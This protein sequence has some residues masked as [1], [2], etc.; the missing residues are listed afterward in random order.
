MTVRFVKHETIKPASKAQ[1]L[2][3]AKARGRFKAQ[4]KDRGWKPLPRLIAIIMWFT[5]SFPLY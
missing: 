5:T 4:R 1:V 3:E 2:F